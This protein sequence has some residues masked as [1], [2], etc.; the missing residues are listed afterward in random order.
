MTKAKLLLSRLRMCEDYPGQRRRGAVTVMTNPI[1]LALVVPLALAGCAEGTRSVEG[2]SDVFGVGATRATAPNSN[3]SSAG[4]AG[5]TPASVA[6]HDGVLDP[7]TDLKVV[8][9]DRWRGFN[10]IGMYALQ[11]DETNQGFKEESFSTIGEL[12]F[13]YV[14]LPLDYRTYTTQDDWLEFDEIPIMRLDA[15]VVW[16]QKHGVHVNLCLHR[17]PGYCVHD[18]A[19]RIVTLPPQQ[20]LDLWSDPA[21]QAA[22]VQHWQML[23]SRYRNVDSNH[24]SFNLINEPVNVSDAIYVDLMTRTIQAIREISADRTLVVDGFDAAKRPIDDPKF[25]ALANVV[26]SRHCYDFPRFQ[27]YDTTFTPGSD[28]WPVPHWPPLLVVQY[29]PGG[30]HS[31]EHLNGPLVVEGSFLAGTKVTI[32]VNQVSMKA[33]LAITADDHEILRHTFIP[34]PNDAEAKTIYQNPTYNI[35]QNTY[36]RDYT[37]VLE[38]A[39]RQLTLQNAGSDTDWM[40]FDSITLTTSDATTVLVPS[41]EWGVPPAKYRIDN[42]IASLISYPPG[43]ESYYDLNQYLGAWKALAAS[44]KPVMIGEVAQ[45]NRAP[46]ADSLRFA[47]F[48]LGTFKQGNFGWAYWDFDST[49]PPGGGGFF[50][51]ANGRS[52]VPT[53]NYAGYTLDPEMLKVFQGN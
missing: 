23:A 42:G 44:G 2:H 21:A 47:D 1:F 18:Y 49:N 6:V 32:H 27:F 26:Q 30:Y 35:Y 20:D 10:L 4:A 14:R 12:G 15:A 41:F 46:H 38:Q 24:L 22:Y 48:M 43:S 8:P 40:T 39:A 25:L 33:I 17:A 36:D 29:L 11:W 51:N 19:G 37:A 9:G 13:N 50:N 28:K 34:G 53:V 7:V 5:V 31:S 45:S 3:E 16:G 52:D